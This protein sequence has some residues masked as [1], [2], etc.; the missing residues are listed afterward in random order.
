MVSRRRAALALALA[1]GCA[2]S[3]VDRSWLARRLVERTGHGARGSDQ[4][5]AAPS[6]PA[7]VNLD[8]GITEDEAVATALWNHPG[9]QADLAQLGVARADLAEAGMLPNP[10][11][12]L[13]LPIGPRQVEGWL[14]WPLEV[15]WQRPRRVAAAQAE[16]ARVGESLVQSGL[17]VARDARVAHADLLVA[18]AR[19]RLRADLSDALTGLA[20]LARRRAAAGDLGDTD[21]AAA[22]A[23]AGAAQEQRARA[24]VEAVTAQAR[25]IQLLGLAEL[26]REVDPVAPELRAEA[27]RELEGLLRV[28]MAA[29]P[30]VRA[31]ELGLE[32]AGARRGW[33][34]SRIFSVVARVDAFSPAPQGGPTSVTGR[35]GLQMTL[36]IFQQNQ[37]GIGRADA[38]IER[39]TWRYAQARQQVVTEVIT[40]RA[41]A[42]QAA[43]ALGPWRSEVIPA[44]EEALRGAER[45]FAQGETSYAAVL[46]ATRRVLDLRLREAELRGDV[47]RAAAQLDRSTGGS[48]GSR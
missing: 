13:L 12:S 34:V 31:A 21:A 26:R 41:Q 25:L 43:A 45:A 14:Q 32:A 30:D 19:A 20:D 1:T 15:L 42:A 44:A 36:P 17:D 3:P 5:V 27:P 6:V 7:G 11:L 24:E 40:A 9:F 16:V 39:A 29:R 23:D 38:E 22:R 33:E 18:R 47:Q 48:H 28:A 10:I 35:A 46:E 4:A 37:G 8:D 2:S